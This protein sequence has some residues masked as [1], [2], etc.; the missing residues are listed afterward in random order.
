MSKVDQAE[1][2][3]PQFVRTFLQELEELGG[4]ERACVLASMATLFLSEM[5]E[6]GFAREYVV[7]NLYGALERIEERTNVDG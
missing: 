1:D 6:R 4:E 3:L 5:E 2:V 7:A